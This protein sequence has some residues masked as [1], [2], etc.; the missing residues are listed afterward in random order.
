[1]KSRRIWICSLCV[2]V[3]PA[4]STTA[5]STGSHQQAPAARTRHQNFHDEQQQQSGR[6]HE[7]RGTV[8]HLS[9]AAAA[10]AAAAAPAA[11]SNNTFFLSRILFL[12]ALG[13]VYMVAFAVSWRQNKA[14]IG[15]NGITP[16]RFLLDQAEARGRLKTERR[17]RWR[18]Q[19]YGSRTR[20]P[21]ALRLRRAV[22]AAI[23][24]NPRLRNCRETLW[25]RQDHAGQPVTT[26]L[27]LAR[28]R[29]KLD[30]V[31]DS[32]AQLGLAMS[33][34]IMAKGAANVPL[35]LGIWI[36]HRSLMAVGGVWY[37]Y[38]WEYQLSELAYHA[39]MMVPLLSVHQLPPFAI[40]PAVLW[41]VRWHLFRVMLGS[42][43]I[44]FRSGDRKWRDLTTM[45]YFYETQPVP[46]PLTRYFH[47]MP[48]WWH[49]WEVL[50]NHFV[51]VVA[52]WLLIV[53][54]LPVKLR[55]VAGLT[56]LIFQIV[57]ITSGN[58]AFL[59][60]MT[61]VPAILCLDDAFWGRLF[62]PLQQSAAIAAAKASHWYTSRQ[63]I[64][65]AFLALVLTLSVPVL[66]NLASRKQVMN[67]SYDPLRLISTYG[68]FGRVN[69]VREEFIV[70]SATDRDGPWREYQFKVKPGSVRR[71]P[72]F[73]SPYHYRLD[74]QMWLAA[75]FHS[76]DRSP[77][78]F[79]FLIKLLQ[80]D[81]A[82]L[83][84][85]MAGDPW[86]GSSKP[87]KYIRIERYRYRFHKPIAGEKDP[88][89][90]DRERID[91][92][93][94]RQGLATIESLQEEIGKRR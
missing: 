41:C 51:E 73:L 61:M 65:Y 47:W 5:F 29:N 37:E 19:Q 91:Q 21:L 46:N 49:K 80:Q 12:R 72:R 6:R 85:L 67:R 74:W 83:N 90:W 25:D 79:P 40:P 59:N 28:D 94:P 34:M 23:D 78:L 50:T 3:A 66:K 93:Y 87:P 62:S 22:G 32:V 55:R 35:L 48:A 8:T 60:W 4:V 16:A 92:I 84:E 70:S 63:V 2:L 18:E 86:E 14:L 76:V 82:I 88:P 7:R 77:W 30:P 69:E 52:P 58:L 26:L 1:M 56:Q 38:G 36:C 15:D 31:L 44:K 45:N 33:F 81:S 75:R 24:R 11:L 54:G 9:A 27:W 42:G 64:S 68:V 43:L 10:A 20:L 57:L 39:A 13:F 89:Y 17:L 53:P 71:S